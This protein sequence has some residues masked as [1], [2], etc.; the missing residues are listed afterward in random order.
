MSP[1]QLALLPGSLQDHRLFDDLLAELGDI[2]AIVVDY[3]LS[4][5]IEAMAQAAI[6]QI[7]EQRLP[8]CIVVG[9]S[10]GGIV[11]AELCGSHRNLISAAVLLDTN[12]NA[13]DSA[14]VAE[15]N[16]WH[17]RVTNSD[18]Q[19]EA[20][21]T[22][23]AERQTV[24]PAGNRSLLIDMAVQLGPDVFIAQNEA[25]L[26]RRNRTGD[27]IAFDGPL[28]IGCG[29][30]DVV[31]PPALHVELAQLAAEGDVW[32]IPDAGHVS[33][34]DN[35]AEVAAGLRALFAQSSS[36]ASAGLGQ[37]AQRVVATGDRDLNEPASPMQANYS[38]GGET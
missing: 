18:A 13:P 2:D 23:L 26:N 37:E 6:D 35:P 7:G 15:R 16:Q 4:N 19:V 1:N 36:L 34:I 31:T 27:L 10:L 25:L 24:D 32:V 11:A 9:L 12:L 17:Q 22:A 30:H 38:R 20:I 29:E 5:S 3:G 14:Q 28:V 21:A 33:T 8:D